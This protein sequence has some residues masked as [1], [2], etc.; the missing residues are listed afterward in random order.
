[1]VTQEDIDHFR[2]MHDDDGLPEKMPV[3]L[4]NPFFWHYLFCHIIGA[5]YQA[6]LLHR[7]E[8]RDA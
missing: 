5:A 6:A 7:A 8:E 3:Q 1:M 4:C 2:N